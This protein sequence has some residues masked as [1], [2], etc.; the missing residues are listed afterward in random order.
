MYHDLRRNFWWPGMKKDI[1]KF[2]LECLICQQVKTSTS[3]AVLQSNL[4]PKWKWEYVTMDFVHG[5][6]KSKRGLDNL[7][8]RRSIDQVNT[9]ST[10][11]QHHQFGETCRDL[12]QRDSETS[13][14]P[15]VNQF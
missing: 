13:Q 9:F 5:F 14:S 7:G 15:S 3:K 4:I 2:I 6:P 1:A 10:Y 11:T 8:D 12:P